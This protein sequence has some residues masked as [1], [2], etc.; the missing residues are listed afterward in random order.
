MDN[1]G[2]RRYRWRW[3]GD[4]S[5]TI[6]WVS[7]STMY[8]FL[9]DNPHYN[10]IWETIKKDCRTTRRYRTPHGYRIPRRYSTV[11]SLVGVLNVF[12]TRRGYRTTGMWYLRGVRRY[13]RSGLVGLASRTCSCVLPE[14]LLE[15]EHLAIMSS[16][17][18]VTWFTGRTS[19]NETRAVYFHR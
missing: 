18:G 14:V 6:S 3:C 4:I 17:S 12:G 19:D 13:S 11:R 7:S 1:D 16:S 8:L 15:R 10:R 9:V 2:N 5:W